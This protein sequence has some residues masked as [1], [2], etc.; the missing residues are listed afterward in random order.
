MILNSE[1]VWLQ[2]NAMGHSSFYKVIDLIRRN[3]IKVCYFKYA[4]AEKCAE[5]LAL[6][7]IGTEEAE[8]T[9]ND[10]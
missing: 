10:T 6:E 1:V 4:G 5:Q 9:E 7:E 3:D 8:I 2:T